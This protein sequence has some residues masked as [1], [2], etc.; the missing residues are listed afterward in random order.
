MAEGE[1]AA[2]VAVEVEAVQVGERRRV[3]ARAPGGDE[4]RQ[5]RRDV[6]P[7]TRRPTVL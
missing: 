7:P 1:V 5:A 4:H 3:A 6:D 2:G